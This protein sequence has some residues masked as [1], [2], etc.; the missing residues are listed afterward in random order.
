MSDRRRS[1]SAIR[2][3]YGKSPTEQRVLRMEV[4]RSRS[5]RTEHQHAHERAEDAGDDGGGGNRR[6][7]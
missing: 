2:R 1:V 5:S 4:R 6:R 3:P 7:R